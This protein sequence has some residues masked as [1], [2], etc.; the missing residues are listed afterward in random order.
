MENER[1]DPKVDA[2]FWLIAL[3]S[4]AI[5]LFMTVVAA[6]YPIS[7]IVMIPVDILTVYLC[8]TSLFGYVE[9]REKVVFIKLGLI[10]KREIPYEKIR[11]FSKEHR[12]YSDSMVC[13]KNSFEH[14][15]IKY[16]TFDMLSVSVVDNDEMIRKINERIEAGRSSRG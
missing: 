8:I 7:L 4:G 9:L 1:F 11:G 14:I 10:M 13:L 5:L 12:F 15:N 16:N 6:F 3:S 2:L